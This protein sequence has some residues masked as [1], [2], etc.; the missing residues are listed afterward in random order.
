MLAPLFEQRSEAI[1][2]RRCRLRHRDAGRLSLSGSA[3]KIKYSGLWSEYFILVRARGLEPPRP[4]R[5]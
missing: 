5:H 2:S 1:P 4:E 3:R